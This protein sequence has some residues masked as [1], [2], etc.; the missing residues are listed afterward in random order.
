MIRGLGTETVCQITSGDRHSVALT[1]G[2]Q[3]FA[4][5]DNSSGQLGLGKLT[6]D[7]VTTPQVRNY[8][9]SLQINDFLPFLS[10]S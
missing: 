4:W 7:K 3:L 8:E 6:D 1:K 9:N 5:G 2:G 10:F